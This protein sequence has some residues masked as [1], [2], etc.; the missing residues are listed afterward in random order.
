[1]RSIFSNY[2]YDKNLVIDPDDTD[3]KHDSIRI[4]EDSSDWRLGNKKKFMNLRRLDSWLV[5]D[6]Q[7]K[8][9]HCGLSDLS[10]KPVQNGLFFS[11]RLGGVWVAADWWLI[12]FEASQNTEF[13]RLEYLEADIN[14]LL[15][16]H[17]S[18]T[19]IEIQGIPIRNSI[20][21]RDRRHSRFLVNS[22]DNE[23]ISQVNP[24]WHSIE[25]TLYNNS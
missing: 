21:C 24:L 6:W 18:T 16:P 8:R 2:R 3:A 11:L 13:L 25:Q 9:R 7:H 19:P 5:S 23:V 22:I 10:F 1:M 15:L 17:I 14:T 12:Y 4:R 20:P